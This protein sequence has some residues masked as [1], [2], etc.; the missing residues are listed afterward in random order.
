M[1]IQTNCGLAS[2]IIDFQW[3]TGKWFSSYL[4]AAFRVLLLARQSLRLELLL[5]RDL[6]LL[7]GLFPLLL[8]V[9]DGRSCE[10]F[11]EFIIGRI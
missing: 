10:D 5:L 11:S 7:L 1:D 2:G 3:E 6:S 8:F 4:V 9:L